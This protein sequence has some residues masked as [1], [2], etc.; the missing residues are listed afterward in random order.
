MQINF[1]NATMTNHESWELANKEQFSLFMVEQK[2]KFPIF[3]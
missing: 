1:I 3:P 2:L